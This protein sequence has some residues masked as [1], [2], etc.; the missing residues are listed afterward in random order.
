MRHPKRARANVDRWQ[1]ANKNKVAE[2]LRRWKRRN[3]AHVNAENSKRK[4]ALLRATS[5][6]ANQDLIRGFYVR[7]QQLTKETGVEHHVDH[8][9]PLKSKL[10]SGLHVEFN[11]RVI[12]AIQ[13]EAKGN[14]HWPNMPIGVSP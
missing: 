8:I 7:A 13:N 10:V 12:P 5:L 2:I 1:A 9:V 11:L 3:A 14:R 6:W 4:A